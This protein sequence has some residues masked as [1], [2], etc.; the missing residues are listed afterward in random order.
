VATGCG[1][2]RLHPAVGEGYRRWRG[3][4]SSNP[5]P[6]TAESI[7]NLTCVHVSCARETAGNQR[8]WPADKVER[9]PVDRLIPYAKNART[10]SDAQI[11]AI[12]ASIKEWGWTTPA[13]VGEDGERASKR[14]E[15]DHASDRQEQD[16]RIVVGLWQER[17]MEARVDGC[18]ATRRARR[19]S[20]QWMRM[21][22]GGSLSC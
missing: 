7:A 8:P 20:S 13:L 15:C 4:G 9:W 5:S 17:F 14:H 6:S 22:R 10:H 2:L 21:L 1:G 12:A 11:A 19:A 18:C 16:C 3:T